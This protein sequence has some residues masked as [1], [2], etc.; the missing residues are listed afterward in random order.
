MVDLHCHMLPGIDDGACNLRVSLE[1][2]RIAVED[3]I[4]TT[5]CTPHIYPG[6]YLNDAEAIRRSAAELRVHLREAGIP[7]EITEG[8]D[9]QMVVELVHELRAGRF[10]T[11]AGSRYFLFEPPHHTVPARFSELISEA[12]ASGYVPVITHPERLTWLSKEYY[13]WLVEAVQQGA[14]IQVTAGALTGRF[15]RRARYWGERLLDDGL[16]HL[17][18]TDAHGVDGRPPLLAE[19]REAAATRVGAEESQR[20]VEVRPRAVLEDRDPAAFPAPAL[21]SARTAGRDRMPGARARW[22][23]RLFLLR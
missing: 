5:A 6:L 11:L 16:V 23:S 12:L 17:L 4:E 3:G 19:G 8:A 7:L 22:L 1:M 15:G 13:P 10:P 20:L 18:A 9:I 21:T 14:W 2:A